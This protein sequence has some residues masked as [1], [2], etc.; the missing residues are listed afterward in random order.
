MSVFNEIPKEQYLL[1][2]EHFFVIRDKYPVSPGH[3]LIISKRDRR[4]FFDLNEEEK[5]E[6]TAVIVQTKQEIEKVYAPDGYN[7]GM[8]CGGVGW[9][10]RDAFSLSCNSTIC[11]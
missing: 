1:E 3:A 5:A 2:S 7:I 6:M 8:N 11:R 4:Q 10:N 9:S